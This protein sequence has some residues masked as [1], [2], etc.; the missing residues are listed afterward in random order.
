[1]SIKKSVIIFAALCFAIPVNAEYVK[2]VIDGK[3]KG[4][5]NAVKQGKSIYLH[6][7]RAVRIFRGS[8]YWQAKSEKVILSVKR[9]R[10]IF[11]TGS[12]SYYVNG[13]SKTFTSGVL[14]YKNDIFLPLDFFISPEFSDAVG[15][16]IYYDDLENRLEINK[17]YNVGEPEYFSFGNLTRITFELKG[18]DKYSFRKKGKYHLQI[19]VPDAMLKKRRRADFKEGLI[20]SVRTAQLRDSVLITVLLAGHTKS[21][22]VSVEE[23][24]LI[25]EVSDMPEI[26]KAKK[27]SPVKT[28]KAFPQETSQETVLDFSNTETAALPAEQKSA[29]SGQVTQKDEI[30]LDFSE[31]S[32]SQT[33]PVSVIGS[34]LTGKKSNIADKTT[35]SR[36]KIIIIDPGHG[37]KD[38]GAV[39]GRKFFEKEVNLSIAKILYTYLKKH[40]NIKVILTRSKDIFIPLHE[41]S[42]YANGNKA[43]MFVSIHANSHKSTKKEGFEIFV[44]SKNASDPWAAE[45]AKLENS[46]KQYEEGKLVTSA[47]ILLHSLAKNEYINDSLG[48]AGC[49]AKNVIASVPLKNRGVKKADFYVLRGTYAPAILVETGFITNKRDRKII[50]SA[51]YRKK[52]TSAIYKGILAYGKLKGWKL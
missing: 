39:A 16:D 4:V 52:L 7:K 11:K 22:Y 46:V 3:N 50:T 2:V 23:N 8:L 12:N 38:S 49:I 33:S 45:V 21:W 6:A 36:K 1:M 25:V 26:A 37:G 40:K 5:L 14:K 35:N 47:D 10:A 34:P 44:L 15:K 24:T 51:S 32:L 42:G 31:E 27:P 28:D 19:L 30:I 13:K 20:K 9:M 41:R 17:K 48:L 18:R 29:A 43:D